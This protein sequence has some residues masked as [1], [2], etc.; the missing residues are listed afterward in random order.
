M[1]GVIDPDGTQWEKCHECGKWV[2]IETLCFE[3]PSKQ[4]E[5]GRDLC[6]ECWDE[7][8]SAGQEQSQAPWL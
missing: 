4:F 8:E 7:F 5:Y 2:R 1:A 3:P 6:Q